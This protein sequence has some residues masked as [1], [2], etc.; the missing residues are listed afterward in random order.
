V[1]AAWSVVIALGLAALARREVMYVRLARREDRAL[2]A[3][4]GWGFA[5]YAARTP[6]FVPFGRGQ[7]DPTVWPLTW[8]GSTEP[9]PVGHSTGSTAGR[10]SADGSLARGKR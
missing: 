4:F 8:E 3:R 2:A 10:V 7:L 9:E 1:T 5:A 6:A